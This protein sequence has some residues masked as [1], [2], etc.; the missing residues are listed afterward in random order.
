MTEIDPLPV[1]YNMV[2]RRTQKGTVFGPDQRLTVEEALHAYT[3]GS[4]Y[5]SH[6]KEVKGRLVPGQLADIAVFDRDLL[7]IDPE[8]IVAARC[9]LTIRGGAVV[10]RRDGAP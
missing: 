2:T 3:S 6:E 10:F 5:A 1:I 7:A 9:E 8:E 4:A